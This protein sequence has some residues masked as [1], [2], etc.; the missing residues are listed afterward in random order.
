MVLESD[1]KRITK[2]KIIKHEE[3]SSE[4][5]LDNRNNEGEK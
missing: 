2:V 3:I 1:S 4:N 5:N